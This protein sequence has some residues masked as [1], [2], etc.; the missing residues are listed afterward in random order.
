MSQTEHVQGQSIPPEI[1]PDSPDAL[2]TIIQLAKSN[3]KKQHELE[4]RIEQ[5]ERF[6]EEIGGI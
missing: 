4:Q 2:R 5:I 3:Y 6:F 1:D